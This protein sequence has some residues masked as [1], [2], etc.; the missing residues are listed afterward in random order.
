MQVKNERGD[1]IYMNCITRIAPSWIASVCA[2]CPLL[3]WGE[4][5]DSPG[6]YY[7]G[8]RD[9]VMCFVTPSYGTMQWELPAERR[10]LLECHYNK[11]SS[12]DTPSSTPVGFR[13]Q[14][15]VFR[16]VSAELCA[17]V[18]DM[19]VIIWS[20]D[21]SRSVTITAAIDRSMSPAGGSLVYCWKGALLQL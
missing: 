19:S 4:P 1:C 9:A 6:P 15:A 20:N 3:K 13:K 5:H 11:A 2:D 7:D 16:L 18:V 21:R 8:S 10:P 12:G 17:V 14:D